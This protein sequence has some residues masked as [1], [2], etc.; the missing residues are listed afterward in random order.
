M[1]AIW[2]EA[3]ANQAPRFSSQ[4]CSGRFT[5]A[6]P[7][8]ARKRY[9][10]RGFGRSGDLR[11]TIESPTSPR[12]TAIPLELAKPAKGPYLTHR[13][14]WFAAW[15]R[16]AVPQLQRGCGRPRLR[17]SLRRGPAWLNAAR[18]HP[19]P[20]WREIWC[21]RRSG[22]RRRARRGIRRPSHRRSAGIRPENPEPGYHRY[23]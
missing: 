1:R 2:R 7:P 6:A 15:R 19:H 16:N 9:S 4:K 21:G 14:A 23:R 11:Q 5:T 20:G 8:I 18:T 3:A 17:W 13:G 12:C 10:H 22:L